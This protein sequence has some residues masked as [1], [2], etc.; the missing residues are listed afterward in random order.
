MGVLVGQVVRIVRVFWVNWV[1]RVIRAKKFD[2]MGRKIGR[3]H[4]TKEIWQN[5]LAKNWANWAK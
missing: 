5:N 4:W 2:K 1:V 3:K